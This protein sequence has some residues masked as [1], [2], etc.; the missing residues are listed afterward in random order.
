[1]EGMEATERRRTQL[2]D[3]EGLL[4]ETLIPRNEIILG[5]NISSAAPLEHNF[6]T[7][8]STSRLKPYPPSIKTQECVEG[9]AKCRQ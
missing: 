7:P 6:S 2:G 3:G 4:I 5:S 9:S 1:M 8:T